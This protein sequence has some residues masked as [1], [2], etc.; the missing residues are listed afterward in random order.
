MVEERRDSRAVLRAIAVSVLTH[1]VALVVFFAVAPTILP[2]PAARAV[3]SLRDQATEL[4]APPREL[5]QTDPNRGPVTKEFTADSL[6][7][8]GS[9][10]KLPRA[11]APPRPA[12]S[13]RQFKLPNLPQAPAPATKLPDAPGIDVAANQAPPPGLGTTAAN[14]PPPPQIEAVEKPKLAFERPGATGGTPGESG[15]IPR[16]RPSGMDEVIRQA[17]RSGGSVVSGDE[18]LM[19]APV[20]GWRPSPLSKQL[21]NSLELLSDPQGTDFRPYLRIVLSAVKRNWYA[22]T[23]ESA[24]MGRQ[25]RVTV[26]FNITRAGQVQQFEITGFSGTEALDRAAVAGVSASQPFPPLPAGYKGGWVRLQLT[27]LYN[28]PR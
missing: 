15:I 2:T 17:A 18:D 6:I 9:E 7:E 5:T 4:I 21:G 23:P 12:L 1:V 27:F 19:C 3:A 8:R 11:G 10:P 20:P 28:L 25:G 13:G 24:R 14:A 26:R 16:Q 22:V